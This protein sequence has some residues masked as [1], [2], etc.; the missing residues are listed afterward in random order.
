MKLCSQLDAYYHG[1]LPPSEKAAFE[2]HLEQCHGCNRTL[3]KWR[4]I[5]EEVQAIGAETI[6]A[7][8]DW[9]ETVRDHLVE[10]IDKHMHRPVW[11][12]PAALWT[13]AAVLLFVIIVGVLMQQFKSS[14]GTVKSDETV[15]DIKGTM[16]A[17][18]RVRPQHQVFTEGASIRI[19]QQN[20]AIIEIGRDRIGLSENSAAR[21]VK[22]R[23]N[24]TQLAL[25]SGTMAC[26]VTPRSGSGSFVVDVHRGDE[27]ANRVS[28]RVIGTQFLLV[29]KE[30]GEL[31]VAVLRGVVE[32]V[33]LSNGTMRIYA[34]EQITILK[35]GEHVIGKIASNET[36]MLEQLLSSNP[37]PANSD[38]QDPREVEPATIST[39]FK[40]QIADRFSP[41]KSQD[42][43]DKMKIWQ[44]WVLA[45]QHK[46]AERALR[47]YLKNNPK[48]VEAWF[49][50]ADC[51]K[52]QRDFYGAVASYE[53]AMQL[54]GRAANTARYRA[55]VL[56]QEAL[57]DNSKAIVFFEQFL[58]LSRKNHP[59]RA[60][61]MLR[62]AKSLEATGNKNR[63]Q[64]VLKN[65]LKHYEST[66]AAIQARHL[67]KGP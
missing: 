34:P 9:S 6:A 31:D 32:I 62:L 29:V 10:Q 41:T 28:I 38:E 22:A 18:N 23:S 11:L 24:Q 30:F 3:K 25:K 50:L 45:G 7:E 17:S 42:S 54:P 26:E 39:D 21:I 14:N 67:L 58:A 52:R 44:N 57:S 19:A 53:Q 59:L 43:I 13:Q 40:S 46:K 61:G 15:L 1:K 33:G 4:I 64:T 51:Q 48:N 56:L 16:F 5:K 65:I 35:G 12:R 47:K 66:A 20:R 60:E 8:P 37:T 49:L 55:G 63:A 2:R 27:A 36:K